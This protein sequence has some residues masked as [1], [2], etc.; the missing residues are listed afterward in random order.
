MKNIKD[1]TI[2]IFAIIGFVA[3]ISGFT[4]QAEQPNNGKWIFSEVNKTQSG[5]K[6]RVSTLNTETGEVR[7]FVD[8]ERKD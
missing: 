8:G 4:N 3:I 5:L 1:I 6:L 7:H 2:S